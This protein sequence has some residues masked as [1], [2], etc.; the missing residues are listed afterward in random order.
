M[1]RGGGS[2]EGEGD[3]IIVVIKHC[4]RQDYIK[5]KKKEL[6]KV[7]LLISVKILLIC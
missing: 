3:E 6:N 5:R 7:K 1:G 4:V 2:K